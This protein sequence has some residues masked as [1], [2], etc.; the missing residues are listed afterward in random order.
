MVTR[1]LNSRQTLWISGL[2]KG[3]S[4][5]RRDNTASISS[6]HSVISP[7]ILQKAKLKHT[8]EIKSTDV[9]N[10]PP[11]KTTFSRELRRNFAPW[12][13]SLVVRLQ[14]AEKVG[15]KFCGYARKDNIEQ[16]GVVDDMDPLSWQGK[17]VEDIVCS[18]LPRKKSETMRLKT[19]GHGPT[20]CITSASAA[21]V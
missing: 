9:V 3:I 16:A 5:F 18:I 8:F 14:G 6:D 15:S 2:S 20:S 4:S 11:R 19:R 12:R 17:L 21:R 1:A 7:H 13:T 10:H